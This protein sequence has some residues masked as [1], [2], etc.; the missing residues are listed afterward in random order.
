M[1]SPSVRAAGEAASESN[2]FALP[3]SKRVFVNRNLRMEPIEWIGFDMDYTLAIYDQPEIDRLSIEATVKK[4]VTQRGYPAA[5]AEIRYPTDFAIRGLLIDKANGNVL[6]MDRYAF[7]GRAF[8]GL[9]RLP[10]EERRALY[11][12]REVR[13]NLPEYHWCDTLYALPEATMYAAIIAFFEERNRAVD[14]EKLFH[15]IRECIDLSH[16]DGTILDVL[17]ADPDRY[18]EKD[19]LLGP[20]LHKLRSAGKRLF[21]LTN[22]RMPYTDRMMSYLL[23]GSVPEYPSWRQF[24]DVAIVGAKK[25]SFFEKGAAFLERDNGSTRPLGTPTLERGRIYEGG[26]LNDLERLTGITSEATL[27]VGDHIY[28]DVLRAKK[29]SYWRTAMIVQEMVAEI[30]A[31]EAKASLIARQDD[32]EEQRGR[33][34]DE[35]RFHQGRIKSIERQIDNGGNGA[36]NG[37][38]TAHA[39]RVAEKREVDR[40]RMAL[41]AEDEEHREL[42][43][44]VDAAFH[45][46]WGSIFKAGTEVSKFGDQIEEYA[47]LYTSRVSNFFSYSPLQ[48]FRSPRALMP[49]EL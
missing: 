24:F 35:L 14:Y 45:P 40:I 4:L 28:G 23:D 37:G 21:L 11:K 48:Y 18:V 5:V 12:E 25:P 49:H 8:H 32:L 10:R 20:T 9:R 41:K 3:R 31:A 46:Y 2:E 44:D 7:V 36:K 27:Y 19:P 1:A 33:L 26:N 38:G 39:Q 47:D 13:T 15:D 22:S 42:S 29:K 17:L 6:K 34:E 30:A 43:L 16:Q